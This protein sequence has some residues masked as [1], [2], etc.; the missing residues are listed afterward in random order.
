M[1]QEPPSGG[2]W[3]AGLMQ[4][5]MPIITHSYDSKVKAIFRLGLLSAYLCG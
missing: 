1:N 2:F 3:F 4:E 5:K